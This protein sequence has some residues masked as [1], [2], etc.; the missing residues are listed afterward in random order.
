MT[1]INVAF[2]GEQLLVVEEAKL[3]ANDAS[4]GD[5]LGRS[6]S[7]SGDT[8][9]VGALGESGDTG[10]AY[11]FVRTGPIWQEEAKLVS[12]DAST[13]DRLGHSVAVCG[14]LVV[15][16]APWDD[17]AGVA[18]G[19]AYIFV[20][21]GSTWSEEAKL[22]ANDAAQGDGFGEAV[23]ISGNV[24]V[25]GAERDD[26]ACIGDP[27]C[28]SGAVYVFVRSGTSWV[29]Q[30]KLTAADAVRTDNFGESVTV[31]GDMVLVGAHHSSDA[32]LWSGS[33]YV[34]RQS[35][36]TWT[37]EA[38]LT[39]SDAAASAGF[40]ASTSV[41]GSTAVVG[42]FGDDGSGMNTGAAYVFV[43]NGTM[44]S[45]QAK[46]IASDAPQSAFFGRSVTISGERLISGSD[47]PL[48]GEAYLFRRSGT[49]WI[50]QQKFTGSDISKGAQFG[51]SSSLYDDAVVIGALY[52]STGATIDHGAAY[53]FRIV[54]QSPSFCDDADG[55]LASCPCS[56]AGNPDSGCDIQQGTGGVMIDL[57]AQETTPQNRV[58]WSGAGFA[59]A[60]TPTSIVIR[61]AGLDAG[62][63]LVFGDGLRCIGTPLV[64]L[65]ATFASVGVVT[66]THGHG[67]GA[68]SGTF[69][70]QLWF[71]NTPI[72]FCDPTAA[73][74]LSNGRTLMW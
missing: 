49:D 22:V 50:E 74:N 19:S 3:V 57:V 14:D 52:Q 43:R 33:A 65:A 30:A 26:D 6:V 1:A 73:F 13:G 2:A 10:A 58:T 63:P 32:G 35:G 18:S 40:G 46:L 24:V 59:A 51:S 23:S 15:V 17:H 5:E 41:S 56:N 16:G 42:A 44:W 38:K 20:R 29:Q 36:T 70:Y 8:I 39:A 69:S 12:S 4:S 11:V 27:L 9:L 55:S 28:N 61:A 25:V 62:S 37:Q 48:D 47:G 71:R 66:H 7:L 21:S 54:Q 45:Q 34:F 53:V 67:I 68:G 64:R 72:M 60:N 31:S